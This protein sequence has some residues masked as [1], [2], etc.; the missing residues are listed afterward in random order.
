M[1]FG[2]ASFSALL[3]ELRRFFRMKTGKIEMDFDI[4]SLSFQRGEW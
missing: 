4:H 1:F 3:P 2:I